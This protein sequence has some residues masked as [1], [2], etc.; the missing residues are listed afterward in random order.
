MFDALLKSKFYTKCKSTIKQTKTRIEMIRKKRDAMLKYLK[1]DM[2]DLIKSGADIN[3]YSRADGLVVELNISSCYDFLEQYCLHISS[4]LATMSKQRECPE[5]CREAVSTLMFSAARLSDIPEL[6]ELRDIFNG[7]Y[8]NSL[9]CY[10]NKEIVSK[11]KSQPSIKDMKLQLMRDIAVES[12]VRWNSKAL[13]HKLSKPQI[14][15]QDSLK[16]RSNEEHKLQ[17]KIDE[18]VQRKEHQKAKINHENART[19]KTSKTK[20]ENHSS[21]GRKEVPGD[22][23]SLRESDKQKRDNINRSSNRYLDD[24]PPVKDTKADIIGKNGQRNDPKI[25]RSVSEEKSDD[26]TPFYYRPIQPSYNK[27]RACIVKISSDTSA[28][29][30]TGETHG[31]TEMNQRG[32]TIVKEEDSCVNDTL[33]KP[34]PKSVRTRMQ[35]MD[36]C[37]EDSHRRLRQGKHGIKIASGDHVDQRDEEEKMMDRLLMHYTRKQASKIEVKTPKPVV[38]LA[39]VESTEVS[40]KRSIRVE[41]KQAGP[42]VILREGDTQAN[43]DMLSPNGHIHPKLPDYDDFVTRLAALKGN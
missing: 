22:V 2:A 4:H 37:E 6:R 36:D 19:H 33:Q 39:E 11:L 38:K 12:G 18:S 34:K 5:E 17:K 1:N 32:I 42:P 13:E 43:R 23:R 29:V 9:E 28:N 14:A 8:G 30:S 3:A 24:K 27:S 7:R 15:V 41:L 31:H 40:R 25:I 10:V 20:R 16:S 35:P 26:N 21:H